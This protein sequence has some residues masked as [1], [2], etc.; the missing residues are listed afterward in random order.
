[1][2]VRFVA[3]EIGVPPAGGGQLAAADPD[4]PG[5][6]FELF[7]RA[8]RIPDIPGIYRGR[9]YNVEVIATGHNGIASG[10]FVPVRV[11]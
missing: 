1:M 6:G 10:A 11:Q 9:S 2:Y 8:Y 4:Y 7:E 3:W 5:Y